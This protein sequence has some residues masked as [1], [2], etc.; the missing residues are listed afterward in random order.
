[1]RST[2]VI[3]APVKMEWTTAVDREYHPAGFRG[4]R[5]AVTKSLTRR[6]SLHVKDRRKT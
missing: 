1:M 2:N 6:Q 4:R 3:T 5:V